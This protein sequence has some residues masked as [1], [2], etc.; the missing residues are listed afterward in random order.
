MTE[1]ELIYWA[2]YYEIKA[3]EEK[4]HATTKTQF[5]VIYNKGFFICGRSSR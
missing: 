1:A 5:K 3:E 4:E 2:G